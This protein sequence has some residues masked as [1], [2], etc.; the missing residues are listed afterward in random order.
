MDVPSLHNWWASTLQTIGNY[1]LL[2]RSYVHRAHNFMLPLIILAVSKSTN[3]PELFMSKTVSLNGELIYRQNGSVS[4]AFES[5]Y[6]NRGFFK[7]TR[8]WSSEEQIWMRLSSHETEWIDALQKSSAV[9]LSISFLGMRNNSISR[10]WN[11]T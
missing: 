3:V 9:D 2:N 10:D 6:Y 4:S 8:S 5:S 1:R 7:R 11:Y